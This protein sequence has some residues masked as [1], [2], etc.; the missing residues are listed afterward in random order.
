MITIRQI[1]SRADVELDDFFDSVDPNNVGATINE[2][3]DALAVIP[4]SLSEVS[5]RKN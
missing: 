5:N 4:H 3:R 1:L 2:V